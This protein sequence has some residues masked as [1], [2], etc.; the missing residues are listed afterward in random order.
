M[1]DVLPQSW[2]SC[3]PL[4]PPP[5]PGRPTVEDDMRQFMLCGNAHMKPYR[6]DQL[7]QLPV[8]GSVP[9]GPAVLNLTQTKI[10]TTNKQAYRLVKK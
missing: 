10:F 8:A 2:F 1:L 3:P 7:G 5:L 4:P 9:S 6:F